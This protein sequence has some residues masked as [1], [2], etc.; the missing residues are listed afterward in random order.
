VPLGSP[1]ADGLD[2][3]GRDGVGADRFARVLEP[4]A[5]ATRP[6][7]SGHAGAAWARLHVLCGDRPAAAVDR[8][9][10][11]LPPAGGRAIVAQPELRRLGRAA[12]CADPGRPLRARCGHRLAGV[13]P[14][15]SRSPR[16]SADIPV[17]SRATLA[18]AGT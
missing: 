17:S 1:A 18:W 15:P 12:A 11:A 16:A 2:R 8:R 6:V 5:E 13:P 10:P 9:G 14:A 3:I 4:P 7:R